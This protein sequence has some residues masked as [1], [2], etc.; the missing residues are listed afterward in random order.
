MLG[1]HIAF[2][3][4][5][6]IVGFLQF[7]LAPSLERA[8]IL[9]SRDSS[10]LIRLRARQRRLSQINFALGIV[11]LVFTAIATAL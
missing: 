3:G 10:D 1:K 11:V 8:R 5:V 9:A 7:G 2:A 4:M 6:L